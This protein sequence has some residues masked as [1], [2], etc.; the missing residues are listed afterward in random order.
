MSHR[1]RTERARGSWL[2]RRTTRHNAPST[3]TTAT[4][5]RPTSRDSPRPEPR[6][7]RARRG[8]RPKKIPP[9]GF[10]FRP[11]HPPRPPRRSQPHPPSPLRPFA[12][13]EPP[14]PLAARRTTASTVLVLFAPRPTESRT[15]AARRGQR[16]RVRRVLRRASARARARRDATPRAPEPTPPRDPAPTPTRARPGARE[17]SHHTTTCRRPRRCARRLRTRPNLARLPR[18]T[19]LSG[20]GGARSSLASAGARTLSV[21]L[22]FARGRHA[23][24]GGTSDASIA[25]RAASRALSGLGCDIAPCRADAASAA[26]AHRRA[27]ARPRRFASSSSD[28]CPLESASIPSTARVASGP[29]GAFATHAAPASVA[30]AAATSDS[31]HGPRGARPAGSA[32]ADHIASY[33]DDPPFEDDPSYDPPFEDDPSYDPPFEDDPSCSGRFAATRSHAR[34]SAAPASARGSA[35]THRGN[36]RSTASG[37]GGGE[38]AAAASTSSPLALASSSSPSASAASSVA[39][40]APGPGCATANAMRA[41]RSAAASSSADPRVRFSP[42]GP[43]R[44]SSRGAPSLRARRLS[45]PAQSPGGS[46]STPASATSARRA[47][48][49]A[50]ASSSE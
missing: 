38:R 42:P 30:A 49:R 17:R 37:S 43:P 22:R 5:V 36:A 23:S 13:N 3:L 33:E 46:R 20:R 11:R 15:A 12:R 26:S 34:S 39:A 9:R 21:A 4:R 1:A 6:S 41:S 7:P 32:S 19:A 29:P 8:R 14:P 35:A 24:S 40:P 18:A 27:N 2:E 25:P 28:L 50:F 48:R 45:A 31:D 10:V 47:D 16:S 44:S